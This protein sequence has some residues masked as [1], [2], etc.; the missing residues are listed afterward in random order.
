MPLSDILTD[1]EKKTAID[2]AISQA[3]VR[4]ARSLSEKGEK[5]HKIADKIRERDWVSEI[6]VD[7]VLSGANQRKHWQVEAETKRNAEIEE[8]RRKKEELIKKCDANYFYRMIKD[9][10]ISIHGGFIYND[11]NKLYIK[12]ICFFLSGDSRFETEL[13]FSFQKGMMILGTAGLGK[14]KVIEAVK[15]N[16]LHPISVYSMIDITRKLRQTGDVE[17]NTSQF[18]LLDDVGSEEETVKYYGT[19]ITWFKDFIESYYMEHK[20]FTN[21][22]ITTN[23]DGNL[24][25][26]KYGYR[27]RSRLREMFN[28]IEL[29]GNDLRK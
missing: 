13:G 18:I 15:G 6:N 10:F 26:Q 8:N 29:K 28:V 20:Y 7:E 25:E 12:A 4:Y 21:L 5:E 16:E 19:D 9:Y 22:L 1:V 24:M 14:T 27:V 23:C 2:H 3:K 17:L 11:T